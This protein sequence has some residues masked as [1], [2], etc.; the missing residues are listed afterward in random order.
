MSS[1]E[2]PPLSQTP[3]TSFPSS[4]LPTASSPTVT[5]PLTTPPGLPPLETATSA[6]QSPPSTTPT[7]MSSATASSSTEP[8]S[9]STEPEITPSNS[10]SSVASTSSTPSSS[11]STGPSTSEETS[12]DPTSSLTS[13]SIPPSSSE[14]STTPPSSSS[15]SSSTAPPSSSPSSSDPSSSDPPPSSSQ[16][17]PTPSS[18]VPPAPSSTS[19]PPPLPPPSTEP[20]ASTTFESSVWI[21]TTDE[22]GQTTSTA[23]PLVTQI[24]TSTSGGTVFTI[25]EVVANPNPTLNGGGSGGSRNAFF[26]NTGAVAGVFVLR[27]EHDTAVSATL[28]AAGFHRAPLDDDDDDSPGRYRDHPP[29]MGHSHERGSSSSYLDPSGR[30]ASGSMVHGRRS[31]SGL[32]MSVAGGLPPMTGAYTDAD[33]FAA[34]PVTPTHPTVPL[35]GEDG[36]FNP[37]ADYNPPPSAFH[38]GA[39]RDRTSS[40]AAAAAAVAAGAATLAAGVDR[41][42]RIS[43]YEMGSLGNNRANMGYSNPAQEPLLA[44]YQG[45]K[46]EPSPPSGGS[47][48]S[49]LQGQSPNGN[50]SPPPYSPRNSLHPPLLFPTNNNGANSATSSVYSTASGPIPDGEGSKGIAL[51]T[52]ETEPNVFRD[53]FFGGS[54]NNGDAQ[55]ASAASSS[56]NALGATLFPVEKPK[57]MPSVTPIATP[58]GAAVST[59]RDNILDPTL[60]E[61]FNLMHDGDVDLRDEEDYSRRMLSPAALASSSTSGPLNKAGGGGKVLGVTNPDADET[62]AS[63]LGRES[64]TPRAF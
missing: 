21:P 55:S 53:Y 42:R 12:M 18:S 47:N 17:P 54:S 31:S 41:D 49:H 30:N 27:L 26:S 5:G 16:P 60:R 32:A 13:S 50:G 39:Y 20:P 62:A 24:T 4:S 63:D 44:G 34:N 59:P 48:S 19:E 7:P 23:P 1:S 37:Y 3:P 46:R 45:Q 58:G 61:R 38:R 25:T 2:A 57:S 56:T 22:R 6:Q 51:T 40:G 64:W 9:S 10:S 36:T 28:A 15:E 11:P 8:A 14:P 43:A 35:V 29:S 33:P 52:D